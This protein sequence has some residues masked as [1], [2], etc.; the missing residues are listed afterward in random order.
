MVLILYNDWRSDFRFMQECVRIFRIRRKLVKNRIR[1]YENRSK[2]KIYI[3]VYE[4]D[5]VCK[6]Q[7]GNSIRANE[8]LHPKPQVIIEINVTEVTDREINQ[9]K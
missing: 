8:T 1:Y 3:I 4:L 5:K 9:C 6:S 2:Y 7:A